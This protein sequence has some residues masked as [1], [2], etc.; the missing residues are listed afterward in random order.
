MPKKGFSA[1]TITELAHDKARSMYLQRVKAGEEQ[2]SFSRYIN[3]IITD[4]IEADENLSLIAPFMQKVSLLGNSIMVKDNKIGRLV[5]VL[6]R[7]REIICLYCNKKDCAHV[8]F[9]YSIPEV[10]RLMHIQKSKATK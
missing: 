3:D 4:R 2:K 8:G 5:E 6:V 10:Y 9:V 7:G 1:M